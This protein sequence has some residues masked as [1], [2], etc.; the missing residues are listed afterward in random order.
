MSEKD[1]TAKIGIDKLV[2]YHLPITKIDYDMLFSSQNQKS[3]LAISKNTQHYFTIRE[4]IKISLI[5]ISD[6]HFFHE[7]ILS[8]DNTGIMHQRLELSVK[9][10]RTCNL[11]NLSIAEYQ[12]IVS[13]LES[14]IKTKY[15]IH[16]T[17]TDAKIKKMEINTTLLLDFTFVEYQRVLNLFFMHATIRN[18]KLSVYGKKDDDT[19]FSK[20]TFSQKNQSFGLYMY[21]KSQ[22]LFD[23]QGLSVEHDLLRIE[24]RMATP[25]KISELFENNSL[26]DIHDKDIAEC[27]K[28][29]FEK[30]IVKPYTKWR[31][32][33][34]KNLKH[35]IE[36]C[37]KENPMHWQSVCINKCKSYELQSG[38]PMLLD[39]EDLFKILKTMNDPHRNRS[40]VISSL[41]RKFML[42]DNDMFNQND[43]QKIQEIFEKVKEAYHNTLALLTNA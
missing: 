32:E 20:E 22:E 15:G 14:Y 19:F 18:A 10:A 3:V 25:K 28:T 27:Y 12:G 35:L 43:I 4:E 13:N 31:K 8:I 23:T 24:F 37:K 11:D 42:E 38:V 1:Y 16:L 2:L 29:Q 26:N 39:K 7:L 36:E 17:T 40:H 21:N 30:R 9:C 34:S 41:K 5:K 6:N 33:N